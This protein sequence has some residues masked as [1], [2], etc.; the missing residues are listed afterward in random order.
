MDKDSFVMETSDYSLQTPIYQAS[1]VIMNTGTF[2]NDIY[3]TCLGTTEVG[4]Q[5]W[6]CQ[7]IDSHRYTYWKIDNGE[8]LSLTINDFYSNTDYTLMTDY[9][10]SFYRD[11]PDGTKH[12]HFIKVKGK[13]SA[14]YFTWYGDKTFHP[15]SFYVFAD[16][17]LQPASCFS[18]ND[19]QNGILQ[20]LTYTFNGVNGEM[21]DHL[22]V[23]AS[24][25]GGQT[26][27]EV[28]RSADGTFKGGTK[29]FTN[30]LTASLTGEGDSLRY[31]LTVYPK[32]CYKVLVKDGCWTY[33]TENFPI[34][35][36]NTDINIT[37]KSIDRTA[38]TDNEAINKRT[39][40][41]NIT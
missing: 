22:S 18:V 37:A 14:D 20:D 12:Y 31:R 23:E 8:K 15:Y 17:S 6:A 24:Y 39:Y 34:T 9:S 3:M 36:S 38:Y 27:L 25:D 26:W 29:L 5:I 35:I 28:H 19:T 21:I 7:G 1:Q 30:T 11:V 4:Y 13:E 2:G 32:D 33:E 10:S 41:A 40:A 16:I